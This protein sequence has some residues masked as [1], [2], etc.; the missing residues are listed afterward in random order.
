M[1]TAFFSQ[2]FLCLQERIKDEVPSIA[3]IDL[4]L[5][6]LEQYEVRPAV[7]FPCVLV[8]FPD[9]TYRELGG[10]NQWGEPVIQL[11]IGFAPF[12][13]ANSAAPV[14]AQEEALQHYELEN[15]VF[16][17]LQGWAA[18]YN[19]NVICEPLVRTRAAT[20]RRDDAYRVRVNHYSTAYQDDGATAATTTVKAAMQIDP[21]D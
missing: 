20:E 1:V 18:D 10:E 16:A 12:S 5:G 3:W 14:S 19:G 9:A 7:A 17:A 2:L 13:S 11:R 21:N 15:E 6:Q 8:D 4:D